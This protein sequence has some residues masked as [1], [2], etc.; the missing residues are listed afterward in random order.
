MRMR[1]FA[2]VAV[3]MLLG[4]WAGLA[5]AQV[6][7]TPQAYIGGGGISFRPSPDHDVLEPDGS[8]RVTDYRIRFAMTTPGCAPPA[9]VNLGKPAPSTG[10]VITI[11]P[12]PA[13]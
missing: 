6:N 3:L 13:L 2:L 5:G 7:A 4:V 12:F 10:N 1:P 8:R 9:E 11:S